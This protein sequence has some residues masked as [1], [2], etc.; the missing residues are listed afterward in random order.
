MIGRVY[1]KYIS[2]DLFCNC[3]FYIGNSSS[4]GNYLSIGS[5][6]SRHM[7]K[8]IVK[9]AAPFPKPPGRLFQ[10]EI[11]LELTIFFEFT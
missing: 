10:G 11:P 7:F 4:G 2:A 3:F 9:A 6:F 8:A 5:I 1:G